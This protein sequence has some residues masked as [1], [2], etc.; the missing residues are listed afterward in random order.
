MSLFDLLKRLFLLIFP[1][2]GSEHGPERE[3]ARLI[4]KLRQDTTYYE[5]VTNSLKAPFAQALSE[6]QNLTAGLVPVYRVIL[7][8]DEARRRSLIE[9]LITQ[10][11]ERLGVSREDLVFPHPPPPGSPDDW[12]RTFSLKKSALRRPEVAEAARGWATNLRLADLCAFDFDGLLEPFYPSGVQA[13]QPRRSTPAPRVLTALTDLYFLLPGLVVDKATADVVVELGAA[14]GLKTD[15][16][17]LQGLVTSLG[18]QLTRGLSPAFLADVIRCVSPDPFLPL[19]AAAEVPD[20]IPALEASLTG[21]WNKAKE[22]HL[23]AKADA[24]FQAQVGRLFGTPPLEVDGYDAVTQGLV[25]RLE[26]GN[27]GSVPSLRLVKNALVRWYQPTLRPALG[28]LF[29]EGQFLDNEFKKALVQVVDKLDALGA[30]AP[31]FEL[32]AGQ[33]RRSR[34][35]PLRDLEESKLMALAARES[36]AP[37]LEALDA[38]A[39]T[40]V[41]EF[42]Q[43]MATLEASLGAVVDDWDARA[44]HVLGNVTTIEAKVPLL[45]ATLS[46]SLGTLS[47]VRSLLVARGN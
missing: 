19:Q 12:E 8:P 46:Q 39:T 38:Q 45:R 42:G 7:G 11:L 22:A 47:E 17:E 36:L 32:E 27:L 20:P 10:R 41:V 30:S 24:E 1:T 4:A 13:A 18:A 21:A 14:L 23:R 5:P 16:T 40:R 43:G 26:L 15:P 6:L 33:L 34:I 9:L 31:A 44:G 3:R 28:E 29:V 35:E 2:W 25:T 37:L